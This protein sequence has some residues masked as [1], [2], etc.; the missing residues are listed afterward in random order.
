MNGLAVSN[1]ITIDHWALGRE[2]SG[3]SDEEQA[4]FLHGVAVG[5][6]DLGGAGHMQ[7]SY[8]VAK[9]NELGVLEETRRLVEL[10]AEFFKDDK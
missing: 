5:L 4:L 1:E 10:L 6:S 8:V 7:L 3:W 9:A 2:V